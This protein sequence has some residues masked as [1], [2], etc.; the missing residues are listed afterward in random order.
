LNA[1]IG[2]DHLIDGL[3]CKG[4]TEEQRTELKAELG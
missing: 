3:L 2:R 1:G 4:L